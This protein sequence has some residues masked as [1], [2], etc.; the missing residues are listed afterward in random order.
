VLAIA[1]PTGM[2]LEQ[3]KG[4]VTRS[5]CSSFTQP[6]P[7]ANTQTTEVNRRPRPDNVI[8]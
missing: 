5:R 8:G 6:R 2:R 1:A 3:A 4:S 7:T